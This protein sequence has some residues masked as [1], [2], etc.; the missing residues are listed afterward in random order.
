MAIQTLSTGSEPWRQF[1]YEYN[2][3]KPNP[4]YNLTFQTFPWMQQQLDF[5]KGLEGTRQNAITNALNSMSPGGRQAM[6]DRYRRAAELRRKMMASQAAQKLK[7]EGLGGSGMEA[8]LNLDALNR[9]AADTAAYDYQTSDPS[10]IL[11]AIMQIVGQG[12]NMT[13]LPIAQG[14][15]GNAAQMHE[16]R[17]IGEAQNAQLSR[18]NGFMGAL[19]QILGIATQ[20]GGLGGLKDLFGKK[21]DDDVVRR[22]LG[23]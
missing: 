19:G 15:Y 12:Q 17:R 13:A 3:N 7:A 21:P 1:Q 11:N 4:W 5:A 16:L 6:V 2:P 18:N 23:I 22:S 8:G 14:L 9:A 10:A 20:L